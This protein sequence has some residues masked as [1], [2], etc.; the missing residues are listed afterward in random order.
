MPDLTTSGSAPSFQAVF[1]QPATRAASAPGRVNLKGEH[2]DSNDGYVLPTVIPQRTQVELRRRDDQEV[3]A[4]S[5]ALDH[6]T[7]GATFNVQRYHLGHEQRGR[8]WLDY[9]QGI[10]Q[11]LRQRNLPLGGFFLRVDSQVP[12]GSG[13][14]SSAA[15]EISVLRALREEFQLPLS[16]R[17][18]AR[19]GQQAENELV[20]APV[21]IMDQ[22][23]GSL[24]EP[25][26]ALLLDTRTLE[27]ELLPL[28]TDYELVVIHS[29]V[30]HNHASGDYRQRRAECEQ[31]AELLG[32]TK[33]RDV[34]FAD[35]WR[36]Q[37]LP[38]PLGRRA[39][40]VITENQRVHEAADAL[41]SGNSA[42]LGE[43]FYA[44]HKSMQED[45]EVSVP[46][47]DLLV[48]LGAH[49]PAIHGARLIGGGFG[50]SVVMLAQRGAGSEAAAR[51]TAA[52]AA[53]TGHT[54]LVLLP[55]VANG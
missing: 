30:S 16:D 51:I 15:L 28:P 55:A 37:S 33:L 44:S 25:G 1:G 39:R 3:H 4:F 5:T 20:G 40:H 36:T 11:A 6:D 17:D 54:P 7:R 10:T 47:I 41:R 35:L 27:V 19:I 32:V 43:L 38:A 13:L 46:E 21:G 50:G 26:Q 9:V 34:P 45:F 2:T 24:G 8:G 48:E 49:D 12:L 23:A 53:R 31:A 42:R 18:L 29:G 52:Y 22:M 14:S